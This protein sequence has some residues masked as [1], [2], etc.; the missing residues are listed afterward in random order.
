MSAGQPPL[1]E[2]DQALRRLRQAVVLRILTQHGTMLPEQALPLA[3]DEAMADYA[4]R[5][6]RRSERNNQPGPSDPPRPC[7]L[8]QRVIAWVKALFR[9]FRR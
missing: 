2:L 9:C 7:S 3:A 4:R 6:S 8:R 5:L 1:S